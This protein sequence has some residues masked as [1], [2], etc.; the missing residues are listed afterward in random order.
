MPGVT[1]ELQSVFRKDDK[2]A[3]ILKG[4]FLLDVRKGVSISNVKV[5]VTPDGKSNGDTRGAEIV[6]VAAK[7]APLFKKDNQKPYSHPYYWSP[8]VLYGNW[9]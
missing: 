4:E 2:S 6:Y 9:H 7:D 5:V 3:G 8:F 1:G